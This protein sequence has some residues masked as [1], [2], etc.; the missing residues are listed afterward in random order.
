MLCYNYDVFYEQKETKME[1]NLNENFTLSEEQIIFIDDGFIIK[2][3]NLKDV[4]EELVKQDDNNFQEKDVEQIIEFYRAMK[5]QG[6]KQC[7]KDRWIQEELETL[8]DEIKKKGQITNANAFV[9]ELKEKGLFKSRS[10]RSI[11]EKI[12]DLKKKSPEK[13]PE[14]EGKNRKDLTQEEANILENE[15]SKYL[16]KELEESLNKYIKNTK[17]FKNTELNRLEKTG[18]EERKQQL[19]DDLCDA[20]SEISGIMYINLSF[21]SSDT[22]DENPISQHP[23]LSLP[24]VLDLSSNKHSI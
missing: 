24:N 23:Y 19:L 22:S 8:N 5:K 17:Q 9:R 1:N 7:S 14:I 4:I 2:Q 16:L 13:Y 15:T 20:E 18:E 12:F 6:T 3:K 21:K 10:N 11:C